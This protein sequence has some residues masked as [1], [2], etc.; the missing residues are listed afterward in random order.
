MALLV[1]VEELEAYMHISGSGNAV[2]DAKYE[3]ALYWAQAALWSYSDYCEQTAVTGETQDSSC[4]IIPDKLPIIS[5]SAM[6]YDEVE[7]DSDDYY[8]YDNYIRVPSIRTIGIPQIITI[9]YTGGVSRTDV[10]RDA[11]TDLMD[12][13]TIGYKYT[14]QAQLAIKQLAEWMLQKNRGEPRNSTDEI[15]IR[16]MIY[17]YLPKLMRI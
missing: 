14:I 9:D 3:D 16:D 4:L 15:M 10:A 17:S 6:Y 1:T 7:I 12:T 13:S 5:V 8:V 11:I 2:R